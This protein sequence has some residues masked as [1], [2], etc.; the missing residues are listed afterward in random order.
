MSSSVRSLV[1][2]LPL[3]LLEALV[4]RGGWSLIRAMSVSQLMPNY[5]DQTLAMSRLL[6]FAS[7]DELRIWVPKILSEFRT[8][9]TITAAYE[10]RS[11]ELRFYKVRYLTPG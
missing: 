6:R 2:R 10:G 7:P 8:A 1:S 5:W 4:E 3:T 9:H 11:S